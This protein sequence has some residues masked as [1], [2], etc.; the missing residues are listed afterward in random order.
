MLSN[1]FTAT[2]T[3]SVFSVVAAA[4]NLGVWTPAGSAGVVCIHTLQIPGN[5]LVCNERPHS[6][7]PTNPLTNG[8]I[9]TEIDLLNGA[10]ISSFT[11]WTSKFTPLQ[12]DTSAFCGGHAQ[13]SNGAIFQVG[14]DY[15]G[16]LS[17]GTSNIYPDGRR[18]RRIYNPCPADAQN[19]V[20]S[21]TSL[22]DMTTERWYPSVA[23]LADGSQIII[24]GSTSNLDYSRL[25]ASENNP[26]YEYYPSKAGQW[27]RTLPILA[28][29]FPFMLYPMVF[30]MPSERVFLFVS[31]KTVIID[32]KTDELSYTVPD[33]P[34]LDHLPWIYP[35]AP[36]MTVLPMTIKNNWEFKIQICGGS[37]ASNTDASPMCWQINP[38]NANPTW[39]KVD[40]LPNP[41]VMIDSIILPDGKIL[42]VNG[43]GGG[44]SGG[45]AGI[46]QDAY[47]PVMTP[48][49]FDPEAPAGKQFSVM[50]P[51]TNYRLYHSGVILVESGHVITTGSEMDNYDD[52]WK[53]NKTNCPPY[54]ILYSAQNNC[55][56]P[57]NYNLERYAPPYLQ[58]AEKSGRPVISSA[59]ASITHKSTFAVQIS[60]T[61]SDISRVTFIR[62][63]TTTHQ[64]NTDQRF[65]ELRILYNTS[66]S[67]IVEAPSGPGIAPPGN[68]MLF[69][70]DK[71][72]IPSVAKTIN[73][74][75]GAPVT[76]S[77][78]TGATTFSPAVGTTS[79]SKNNVLGQ[80][81]S[82]G[83]VIMTITF[84]VAVAL[85]LFIGSL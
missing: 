16:V 3:V 34:V 79:T 11:Q 12:M 53:Y 2:T 40:D 19:C 20:G 68:W 57:F 49:L 33:M 75:L 70:L 32:P 60:S 47:N 62:Y 78:P 39:K 55:T 54:P 1:L 17:D 30:T 22:S 14:G 65:I 26:T 6:K 15:T 85:A 7:Y 58:I 63:S 51:A 80:K 10:S 45:D 61:V 84:G 48:N 52:Y 28:W 42:Y 25:N 37:K 38:E 69:V 4:Q 44:V 9:S 77:V 24:G 82:L 29:A 76:A 35:Y 5:K 13:M 27:P 59:P 23:T 72:G 73:L 56:Q 18:G 36:T 71:N 21:W 41:R 66:N 8:M 31:N 74:Q 64:T 67:I 50:A 43:A 83:G 81:Q 46:V